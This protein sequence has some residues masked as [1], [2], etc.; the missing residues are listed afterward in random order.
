MNTQPEKSFLAKL[1]ERKVVR[2][3][4]VY[5]LVGWILIQ[6]GEATF[7]ALILPDWSMALLIVL[8]VPLPPALMDILISANI[9]LAA[10]VLHEQGHQQAG[11]Q[12]QDDGPETA[13]HHVQKGQVENIDTAAPAPAHIL[14]APV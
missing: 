5:I 13:G 1:K 10:V 12:H 6:I 2:V 11:D 4:L 8:V 3:G 7:E 9:S 14:T